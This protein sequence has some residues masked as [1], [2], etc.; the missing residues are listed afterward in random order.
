MKE[1]TMINDAVMRLLKS[2]P[3]SFINDNV[4]FV[5]DGDVNEYFILR[6]CKNELDIQCK[7]LEWFSRGAYKTQSYTSK[8]KNDAFHAKMLKGINKFL[9]T[10][11]TREDIAEIYT[12][13]G[14]CC[15]HEKTLR[16]I[17][18]GYDMGILNDGYN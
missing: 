14:N 11:F 5:A 15:N 16:F 13:L 6:D 4:E 8:K 1:Y 2:F 7:V 3:R 9:D 12:Y 18:S 17:E 10:K